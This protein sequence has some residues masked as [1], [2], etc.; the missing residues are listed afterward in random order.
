MPL[1]T[2]LVLLVLLG[3]GGEAVFAD[4]FRLRSGETK[5]GKV[6]AEDKETLLLDPGFNRPLI[7]IKKASIAITD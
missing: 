7:E 1:K 3:L 4:S 5:R 6:L 2:L